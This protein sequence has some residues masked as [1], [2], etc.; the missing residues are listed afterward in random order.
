MSLF[1]K[2]SHAH[3]LLNTIRN[4]YW[5]LINMPT[6][7]D[8]DAYLSKYDA[9]SLDLVDAHALDLGCGSKP[10]NPFKAT[11]TFG[12]DIRRNDEKNVKS[13]DLTLEPIPFP[14]NT[15][16]YISALDFLEHVPRVIYTPNLKFAFV[17]LMNE[18][19]RTLKQDGIF[20]S[21]TPIYPY[22]TAFRDPTHVNMMTHETFSLYFDDKSRMAAMYGFRGAFVVLS[23]AI[24]APYLISLLKK[25]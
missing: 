2:I 21:R 23:Q 1:N 19:W 16:D 5:G 22:A 12:I 3:R 6:T 24:K 17:E 4:D 8:L 20:L 11:N 9:E 7:D 13:A 18:V 10:S 15:F 25:A 14:D